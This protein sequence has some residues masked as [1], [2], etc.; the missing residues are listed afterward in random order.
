[1]KGEFART[2][3]FTDFHTVWVF[4]RTIR[5]NAMANIVTAFDEFVA[6]VPFMVTGIDLR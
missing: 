5:N 1:M 2:V 3:N 6:K 4:T